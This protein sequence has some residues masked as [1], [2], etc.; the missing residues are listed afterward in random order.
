M[1]VVDIVTNSG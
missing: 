1:A